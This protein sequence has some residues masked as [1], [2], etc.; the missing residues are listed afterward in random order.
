MQQTLFIGFLFVGLVVA[1][2]LMV[3]TATSTVH[4]AKRWTGGILQY[5]FY[6][7]F[8]S[9]SIMALLSGRDLTG[10]V[11]PDASME[12]TNPFV[13]WSIRAS[14]LF[15][16][17]A[18]LDQFVRFF[19]R[20]PPIEAA[21]AALIAGIVLLW[22]TN[23]LAPAFWSAHPIDFY[24]QWIYQPVLF[25]GLLCLSAENG[26]MVVRHCRNAV[27][28]FC[29]GSLLLA[30]VQP[31]MAVN[32]HYE[33][34]LLAHLPRLTGLATHPVTMG[35]IAAVGL[36]C[37]VYAPFR[38]RIW[39][40]FA[41]LT[42]GT[43]LL[44]SQSKTTWA[45]VALGIPVLVYY[46]HRARS[47]AGLLD[48][49][50][51]AKFA[52]FLVFG[53]AML[54]VLLTATMLGVADGRMDQFTKSEMGAQMLSLTGRDT[55]WE[56]ALDEWRRSPVFGYGL[57]LFDLSYRLQIGML[58]ATDGHN[59]FYD[60]LGRA[61]LVG[62]TGAIIYCGIIGWLGIKYSHASSG[63]S[64]IL[65]ISL[66][67]R[68]VSEVPFTL[69]VTNL[70]DTA[71]YLLICVMVS[72]MPGTTTGRMPERHAAATGLHTSLKPR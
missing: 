32:T 59:Q 27:F 47:S 13:S 55:I 2:L 8:I 67:L 44:L 68:T 14:S 66:L 5:F 56:I 1:A 18:A 28:G 31:S 20:K 7:L 62:A 15:L 29:L 4:I 43:A 34:G 60:A 40:G 54:L 12:G 9:N 21:R 37:L 42:C 72:C 57:S 70:S 63:L 48:R 46:R 38:S 17:L 45:G 16:L 51:T 39:M 22:L 41:L 71:H 64:L 23:I 49:R 33:R 58:F 3:V 69:H 50:M 30:L 61:G 53:L 35:M 25:I 36:W 26:K 24:Y 6:A 10:V 52:L 11:L 19:R 65:A